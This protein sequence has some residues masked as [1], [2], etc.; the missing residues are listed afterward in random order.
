MTTPPSPALRTELIAKLKGLV[1]VAAATPTQ[2][3][4]LVEALAD[5]LIEEMQAG[6]KASVQ[7]VLAELRR[8]GFSTNGQSH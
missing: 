5:R 4:P 8:Q 7:L 2:I 6:M 3:D 1:E